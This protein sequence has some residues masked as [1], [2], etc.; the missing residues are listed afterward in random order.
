VPK[1]YFGY[2]QE[3]KTHA[4][5]KQVMADRYPG[6]SFLKAVLDLAYCWAHVRRDFLE[7]RSEE[8]DRAWTDLWVARIGEIYTLNKARLALGCALAP[9]RALPAPF[10]E[11][12]AARMKSPQYQEADKRLREA[13]EKMAATR[14]EELEG[15]D[16]RIPRAR[17][18]KASKRTGTGSRSLWSTHKSPW[19]TTGP[20]APCVPPPSPARTSTAA[21]RSG[22]ETSWPCS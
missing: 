18:S 2:D 10:V 6:Y 14:R 20:N 21:G 15:K 19:T 8:K 4:H 12:D 22:A 17:S 13:V 5:H 11:L 1:E 7:E 16:L 3:N 9:K